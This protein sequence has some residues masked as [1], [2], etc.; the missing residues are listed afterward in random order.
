MTLVDWLQFIAALIIGALSSSGLWAYMQHR[1]TKTSQTNRLL[2]G[3]AYEKI[4]SL[5]MA[6]IERGWI[7]NDEYNDFRRYLYEPYRALGG[8][9]VTE[10]IMAAVTDLPLKQRAKYSEVLQE[11]KKRSPRDITDQL[12]ELSEAA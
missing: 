1:D 7:T 9:G 6:Y 11:A 12:D 3:L 8:N 10:R 5:G 4:I 2:Q